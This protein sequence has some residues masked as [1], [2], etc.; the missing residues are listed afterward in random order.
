M[1]VSVL[2]RS[3]LKLSQGAAVFFLA[4]M[5]AGC[6]SQVARFGGVD[7]FMV[8][9]AV[10]DSS[11]LRQFVVDHLSAQPS[12]ASTRTSVIFDYHRNALAASFR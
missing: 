9:V 5:A 6:S 3:G 1:Q 7:D 11:G 8:H 4:G 12:V 2:K 10:A